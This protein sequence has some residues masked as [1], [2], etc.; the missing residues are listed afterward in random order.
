MG[1]GSTGGSAINGMSWG[2][3]SISF[4]ATGTLSTP[5][6]DSTSVAA[7]RLSDQAT[8]VSAAMAIARVF[9]VAHGGLTTDSGFWASSLP[10]KC[11]WARMTLALPTTCAMTG[12]E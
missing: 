6:P 7:D 9:S 12:L 8:R 5:Y 4:E 2:G 10:G 11:C 1:T 3:N